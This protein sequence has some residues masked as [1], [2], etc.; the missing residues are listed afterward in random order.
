MTLALNTRRLF[1]IR[2]RT[3]ALELH[4][5]IGL[6]HSFRRVILT[7]D[8]KFQEVGSRLNNGPLIE[9][10]AEATPTPTA[11]ATPTAATESGQVYAGRNV[12]TQV[13]LYA[14]DAHLF[15]AHD[16]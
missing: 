11:A 8:R 7:I 14:V 3:V 2:I 1:Q 6:D 5:R 12:S 15:R 9:E 16:A 10:G 13:P 4:P